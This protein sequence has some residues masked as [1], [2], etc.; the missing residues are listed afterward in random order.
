MSKKNAI[1]LAVSFLAVAAFYLYLYRD[2]FHKPHIQIS[3]TFRP[4]A[5]ALS[6]PPGTDDEPVRTVMFGMEH[7]YRL[8]SIKVLVLS[9]LETNKYSHPIWDMISDSNSAPTRAFAYGGHIKGMHPSVKGAKPA[10]L[11][12]NV[13]YRLI[14]QAGN[15]NGQHDFTLTEDNRSTATN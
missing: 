2:S 4:S 11:D 1:V 8:T 14:V 12:L 13:P 6:H 9:D 3:H 5:W 15:I 10:E 7:D